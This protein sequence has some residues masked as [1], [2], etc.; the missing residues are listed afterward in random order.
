MTQEDI[1]NL[2]R[3]II[4]ALSELADVFTEMTDNMHRS[5]YVIGQAVAALN[6]EFN[7]EKRKE[8]YMRRYDRRRS[9]T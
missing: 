2:E 9:R 1:E 3:Q 6:E 7:K 4:L 8:K 5:F